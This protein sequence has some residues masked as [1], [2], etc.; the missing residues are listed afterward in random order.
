MTD[1]PGFPP[2]PSHDPPPPPIE[3]ASPQV[4][5]PVGITL[6]VYNSLSICQSLFS[7]AALGAVQKMIAEMAKQDPQMKPAADLYNQPWLGAMNWVGLFLGII[8]LVGSIQLLR[9]RN[10]GLAM[11][12]AIVTLINPGG[13]CCCLFGIGFGIWA[14][15]V[16]LKPEAQAVFNLRR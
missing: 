15:V 10:Y 3:V 1:S 7:V 16:L 13:A 8:A 11:T 14:L 2:P 5:K 4:L 6:V 12:G 9:G